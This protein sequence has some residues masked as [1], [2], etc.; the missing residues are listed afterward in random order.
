MPAKEVEVS[1]GIDS[2]LKRFSFWLGICMA[3]FFLHLISVADTGKKFN[4][5]QINVIFL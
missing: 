2:Q 5:L 4:N 1:E 3:F